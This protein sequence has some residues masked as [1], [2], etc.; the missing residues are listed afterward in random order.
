MVNSNPYIQRRYHQQRGL[1]LVEMLVS[2]AI[3]AMLLTATMVA[4]DTSFRAYASAA[5]SASTQAS[6]RMV[7]NRLLMMIR[8]STAHGPLTLTEAKDFD[9]NATQEES[10]ITSNFLE[11]IDPKGRLIR[12]EHNASENTLYLR[13][14]QNG[15]FTYDNS[16]L[17]QPLLSGVEKAAFYTK[18][19]INDEGIYQLERGSI[20]LSVVPD[21]DNTL[22]IESASQ[23]TIRVIASTMPRRIDY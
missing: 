3:T 18:H 21:R 10:T 15:N 19:R 12:I 13:V 1:S 8:N 20:D 11:M 16:E 23:S 5:E 17:A 9:T 22:A 4:I 14:D 2:L 6:T 7:I